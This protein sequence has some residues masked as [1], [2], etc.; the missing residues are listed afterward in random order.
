[1]HTAKSPR[2]DKPKHNPVEQ[3]VVF[4]D[5]QMK[6][7]SFPKI[8][9]V[10][11]E[12]SDSMWNDLQY[13]LI[14][15]NV[16]DY[17]YSLCNTDAEHQ[18]KCFQLYTKAK[19]KSSKKSQPV[20][21]NDHAVNGFLSNVKT[22]LRKYEHLVDE[23]ANGEISTKHENGKSGG[24][25]KQ[26]SCS[27]STR[28]NDGPCC[29]NESAKSNTEISRVFEQLEICGDLLTIAEKA[30]DFKL[31]ASEHEKLSVK[32]NTD[33][34][35]KSTMEGA[36]CEDS[37]TCTSTSKKLSVVK[38]EETASK[39]G[40][41]ED[42][43]N[44]EDEPSQDQL[45]E[46]TNKNKEHSTPEKSKCNKHCASSH[47]TSAKRQLCPI[48]V[49]EILTNELHVLPGPNWTCDED[50]ELVQLLV[51]SLGGATSKVNGKVI[52]I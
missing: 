27:K 52:F 35:A 50:T 20:L 22:I 1:M 30:I 38:S 3:T 28:L 32:T 37:G 34:S 16:V 39:L 25:S 18:Q 45:T 19:R 15:E 10:R 51:K 31:E 14:W 33:T 4:F 42:V 40:D 24:F 2:D 23:K 6:E 11:S 5:K 13:D 49:D 48:E 9:A 46:I 36:E 43:C 7:L 17:S 29:S 8:T 26:D 41:N 44:Q 47:V 21:I 12:L